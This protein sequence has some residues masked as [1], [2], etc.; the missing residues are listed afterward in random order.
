MEIK[1][2]VS[3]LLIHKK[4]KSLIRVS[5][6]LVNDKPTAIVHETADGTNLGNQVIDASYLTSFPKLTGNLVFD[7]KS[8][9]KHFK[10]YGFKTIS[11]YTSTS[12]G[13]K[14]S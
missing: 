10:A 7:L 6:H 4:T 8:V 2:D 3:E 9:L 5:L 12:K 14:F 13:I 1:Y 11:T